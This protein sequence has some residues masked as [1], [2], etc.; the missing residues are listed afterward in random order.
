MIGE[1]KK[2]LLLVEDEAIIA[3]EKQI[4]L[5]KYGYKVLTATSGEKAV[6]IAKENNNIDLILMVM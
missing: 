3:F 2:T 6:Q 5:E 1:D 4:E